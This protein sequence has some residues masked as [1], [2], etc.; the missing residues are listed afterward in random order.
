MNYNRL[1]IISVLLTLTLMGLWIQSLE[2][3][4]D[5]LILATDTLNNR[6]DVIFG[7]VEEVTEIIQAENTTL[8]YEESAEQAFYLVVFSEIFLTGEPG[9]MVEL[10]RVESNFY[11]EA[12]SNIAKGIM[13]VTP[14]TF[15]DLG[16]PKNK[17]WEPAYNIGAGIFY[18]STWLDYFQC[19][20]KAIAAYNAGPT[21]VIGW[22]RNGTWD[23][24]LGNCSQIPFPETRNHLERIFEGRMNNDI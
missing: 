2:E 17:I 1:V 14:A 7:K 8:S 9:L 5:A 19:P 13:Q 11:P 23:G 24:S 4:I 22:L 21:R 15:I 6:L 20:V 12:H 3:R 16:F 18:F 10:A